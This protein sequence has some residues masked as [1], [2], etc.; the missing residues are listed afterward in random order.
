M[1]ITLDQTKPYPALHNFPPPP[2]NF[3]SELTGGYTLS[4]GGNPCLLVLYYIPGGL[5]GGVGEAPTYP[6]ERCTLLHDM[7]N[8]K[9]QVIHH[10]DNINSIDIQRHLAPAKFFPCI[11]ILFHKPD[12]SQ[13]LTDGQVASLSVPLF[14]LIPTVYVNCMA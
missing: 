5:D 9:T 3:F 6:R 12:C 10:N 11:C 4:L 1:K 13:K 7:I 8:L 14:V 2:S